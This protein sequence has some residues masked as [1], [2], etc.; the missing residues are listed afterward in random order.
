[1]P[2][3]NSNGGQPEKTP[4]PFAPRSG[5]LPE[6][7]AGCEWD[8]T[9]VGNWRFAI[10]VAK[11][12]DG[13]VQIA[14]SESKAVALFNRAWRIAVPA[15]IDARNV[16]KD[17]M[18]SDWAEKVQAQILQFDPA[19][20]RTRAVRT[21][22]TVEVPKDKVNFTLDELRAMFGDRIQIVQK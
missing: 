20:V 19:A 4:K 15:A 6:P 14:K 13:I 8:E 9:S 18:N 10:L 22:P 16:K 7:P 21:P 11:S 12:V 17:A 2:S 5:K 1:M 3:S